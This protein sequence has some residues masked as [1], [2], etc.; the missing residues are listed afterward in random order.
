MFKHYLSQKVK[1][2]PAI[3]ITVC[4]FNPKFGV[5]TELSNRLRYPRNEPYKIP[6]CCRDTALNCVPAFCNKVQVRI[7]GGTQS[8]PS[9]VFHGF[10]QSLQANVTKLALN[11][12]RLLPLVNSSYH[13]I[14]YIKS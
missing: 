12:L 6:K 7:S 14:L 2:L 11:G 9:V 8:I 13:Q 5:R 4:E 10:P 3:L 1:C